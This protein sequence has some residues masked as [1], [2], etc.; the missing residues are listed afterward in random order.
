MMSKRKVSEEFKKQC[1]ESYRRRGNR[2]AES[3]AAELDVGKSTLAKW[4]K[5]AKI[6]ALG[7]PLA[8]KSEIQRMLQ[9]EKETDLTITHACKIAKI[10]RSTFYQGK[11]VRQTNRQQEDNF[12]SKL[13]AVK[14]EEGKRA[15]GKRR[16]QAC[17]KTEGRNV[18]LER[19]SRLMKAGF[20][21]Q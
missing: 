4:V 15:Y 20:I 12:L 17:L 9:L 10:S 3:V 6:A 14:F 5:E 16:L 18:S 21:L 7:M 8:S 13:I 1:V 19:I 11:S 2:S